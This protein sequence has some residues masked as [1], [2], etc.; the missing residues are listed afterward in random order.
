MKRLLFILFLFSCSI[1]SAQSWYA[2]TTDGDSVIINLGQVSIAYTKGSGSILVRDGVENIQ[3]TQNIDSVITHSCGDMFAVTSSRHQGT[4]RTGTRFAIN[5]IFINKVKPLGTGSIILTTNPKISFT[6]T[7]DYDDIKT[8]M[9]SC[10]SGTG[11]PSGASGG[12]LA[13]STYPNPV[14]AAN[15]ITSAKVLNETLT[16]DD[17]DTSSVSTLEIAD[18]GVA[19]A[20]LA[21][22]VK[23]SISVTGTD[24]NLGNT[25][26]TADDARVYD[27]NNNSLDFQNLGSFNV[28]SIND[29][30]LQS[31][32]GNVV[33]D[34]FNEVLIQGIS[35]N[36]TPLSFAVFDGLGEDTLQYIT[37]ADAKNALGVENL[38]N[39]DL[40]QTDA[41]RVYNIDGK[42]FY[43][44]Q[45][46]SWTAQAETVV[47][48]GDSIQLGSTVVKFNG[49]LPVD[50]S[51]VEIL[52]LDAGVHAVTITPANLLTAIG[53]EAALTFSTGL[54]RTI[55]TITSNLSTGVSGGQ[56]VIGS[57]LA[58]EN[59]TL[60]STS[61]A[62]KGKI[63]FG[64][65]VYNEN[66]E[67]LGIGTT[68]PNARLSLL[69]NSLGVTQDSTAGILLM[70][71]T[72][73]TV[74]AQQMSPPFVIGGSGWGTTAPAAQTV[75]FLFDVLP[76]QGTVPTGTLQ[77]KSSINNAAFTN[78]MTLTSGGAVTA[79]NFLAAVASGFG[80]SDGA[81]SLASATDVNSLAVIR[82]GYSIN[83]TAQPGGFLISRSQPNTIS[84]ATNSYLAQI[85]GTFAP[86]SGTATNT[87][88]HI[89]PVIN[90]TGGASGKTRGI[91]VNPTLTAAADFRGIEVV[92]GSIVLP[93]VAK[94]G[95]YAI[96]TSDY[97][98]NCTS[99][100]F[101][102][103]LPTSVGMTGKIY[104]IKNSG[105]GTI[106]LD[107]TGG[108]LIDGSATQTLILNVSYTVM[109]D[110]ANWIIL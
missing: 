23:D 96:A 51:P 41:A 70:N 100:T 94:T 86:T 16:T 74:G 52:G 56:S 2:A 43:F 57:T 66:N 11:A 14:I 21:Q 1:L 3:L 49:S 30:L 31:T 34:A 71:Y 93:Y 9:E 7:E 24:T 98:I 47:L 88:L 73:A 80:S 72:P 110:G 26:I 61:H 103:T 92:S 22:A 105:A 6:V 38:G 104:V 102:V 37:I 64:N 32:A 108:Q 76:V 35:E 81:F 99:G 87:G 19:Y 85:Y 10:G 89:F 4:L 79:D 25:D 63:G 95:T 59:L 101:N 13:G 50:N 75:R 12:D 69:A 109:S 39:S 65:S 54:T 84:T 27:G 40:T 62:T 53:G 8:T 67:R 97:L 106:T 45:G 58:G 107:C 44:D 20:D 46:L 33:L 17:L 5:R 60:S 36:A 29:I 42:D 68:A 91:Y 90:Q 48:L 55:N 82:L 15:K 83:G 78:R 28:Q 77:I 18:G